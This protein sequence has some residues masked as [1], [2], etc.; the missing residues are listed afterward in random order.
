[1][2]ELVLLGGFAAFGVF[3][4]FVMSKLDRFLEKLRG[5]NGMQEKASC[6]SVATSNPYVI[7]SVS[8]VFQKVG[9]RYPD[10]R[11]SVSVGREREA[12]R[13]FDAGDADVAIVSADAKSGA[14]AQWARISLS[15]PPFYTVDG[16]VAVK[17][18]ETRALEQKVLW[19][20]GALPALTLEFIHQ[21]CRHRP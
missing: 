7:P 12:L 10:A 16:S 20:N 11:C 19:K 15:P 6:I 2:E 1:M 17:P 14:A 13:F 8:T 9:A 4:F 21:L 18:F 5:Q 3:G